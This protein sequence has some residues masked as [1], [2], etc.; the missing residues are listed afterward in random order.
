MTPLK[1]QA[2]LLSLVVRL[3]ESG[4]W[5]GE[6]HIQKTTYFLQGPFDVPLNFNFILYKYGPFSFDLNDELTALRADHL[7]S[8][9]PAGQYGAH[10]YPSETATEFLSRFPIT[11]A[12][13]ASEVNAVA[14]QLGPK[15]VKDLE[16]CA[17]AL[18]V[19]RTYSN[20]SSVKQATE[21]NRIKPHVTISEAEA[22]LD[23]VR[24]FLE[25]TRTHD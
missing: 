18:Y 13:Y 22:A 12:R 2:V 20:D 7:I 3:R 6:T 4:S 9:V 14:R 17:T 1:R 19:L 11:V 25:R 24:S 8:I 23:E 5:C 16:R 21:L 15:S 10:L